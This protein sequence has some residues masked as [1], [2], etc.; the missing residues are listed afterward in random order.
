M[1]AIQTP[2][3]HSTLRGDLYISPTRLDASGMTADVWSYPLQWMIWLGGLLA[4]A[5]AGVS[6]L[7]TRRVRDRR[8][9]AVV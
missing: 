3:V 6:L 1:T 5:G 9:P 4:A 7:A 2:A 8:E